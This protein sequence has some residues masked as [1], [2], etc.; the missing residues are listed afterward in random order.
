MKLFSRL[1]RRR[2]FTLI[3][4]LVVI[5]IIAILAA[6]LFPVFAQARDKARQAACLSNLKQIG[7]ATMM[8]VQD[9]DELYPNTRAWG[10]AWDGYPFVPT[11]AQLAANRALYDTHVRYMPDLLFPYTKNEGI[12]FC[13]SAPPNAGGYNMKRNGTSYL[14][15]HQT[16]DCTGVPSGVINQPQIK[17]AGL[18]MAAVSQPARAPLIHDLPYWGSASGQGPTIHQNGINVAYAD[19]HAKYSQNLKPTEDWWWTHS[20]EGW[21]A[22]TDNQVSCNPK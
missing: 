16:S 15:Q 5:A 14:W 19:G 8:Y 21:G 3:E 2:V 9:Y 4:L 18:S 7:T 22:A 11:A 1:F 10:R 6:I 12:F 20:G 17:V 13:P